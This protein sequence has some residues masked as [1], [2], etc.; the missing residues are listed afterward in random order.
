MEEEY[1][2]YVIYNPITEEYYETVDDTNRRTHR[3]KY[4]K[5]LKDA[6]CW[7]SR[8]D[9]NEYIREWL[10]VKGLVVKKVKI[11]YKRS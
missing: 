1:T 6:C 2:I 5:T 4:C 9:A 10:R 3:Y 7:D 11:S 8:K